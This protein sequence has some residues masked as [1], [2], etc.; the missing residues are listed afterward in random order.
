[1]MR[2]LGRDGIEVV[3]SA[4]AHKSA[5]VNSQTE[6]STNLAMKVDIDGALSHED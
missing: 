3:S 6:P 1:M 2:N 4:A 5:A